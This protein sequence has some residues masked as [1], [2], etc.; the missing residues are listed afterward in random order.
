MV[1]VRTF[2]FTGWSWSAVF[3]GAI[4]ALVFQVLLVMAGF[5][6][7][8]LS[9]DVPTAES[10]PTTASWAVFCWWA[11][12]GVISAFAGGWAAANFSP[13]FTAEGRAAHGLI[14]WA[15][16][17]LLVVGAAGLSAS[18]SVA[19]D[20]A[21]PTVTA[22]GHYRTFEARGTAARPTQAQLEQARR[23]LSLAMI[24]SFVALLVGAGAAVAGSQWLPEGTA[25][26]TTFAEQQRS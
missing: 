20:L 2:S 14:A 5:G 16:A 8:L 13:S 23:Y 19:G 15:L 18:N 6:F 22:I 12:S 3:V 21:G 10:A 4:V 25:R 17:T 9:I 26:T 7:G 1:A 11:V 24:G